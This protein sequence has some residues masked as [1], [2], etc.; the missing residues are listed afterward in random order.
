MTCWTD[1]RTL[2]DEDRK[3]ILRMTKLTHTSFFPK[4]LQR[5]SVHLV[6]QVFNDKTVAALKTFKDKLGIND[7]T[8]IFVK[9]VTDWF[10]MLNVKTRFSGC[11]LRYDCR[12]P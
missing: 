3:N 11:H 4:P 10:N 2:Y 7:G 5:Q 12:S 8:I 6:C 1:I 9:L